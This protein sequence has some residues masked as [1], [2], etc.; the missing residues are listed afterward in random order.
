[1]SIIWHGLTEESLALL[2]VVGNNCMCIF[3]FD[4]EGARVSVCDAHAM[5]FE[6]ERVL[7]G[8]QFPGGIAERPMG[9]EWLVDDCLGVGLEAKDCLPG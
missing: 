4:A 6:G 3:D 9:E 1:M 5:L 8:P 2:A 7:N